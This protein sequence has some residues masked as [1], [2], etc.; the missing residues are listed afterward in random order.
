M[1]TPIFHGFTTASRSVWKR[2][3]STASPPLN[4]CLPP[5][6]ARCI[7]TVHPPRNSHF[8]SAY[9]L[10]R[11]LFRRFTAAWRFW[12]F[13]SNNFLS[14]WRRIDRPQNWT[15]LPK[16]GKVCFSDSP[17]WDRPFR[18]TKLCCQLTAENSAFLYLKRFFSKIGKTA[19]AIKTEFSALTKDVRSFAHICPHS[20]LHNFV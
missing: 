1:K 3:V 19:G 13:L 9:H 18:G 20:L 11:A 16:I 4:V 10:H 12:T 6:Q 15:H 5:V 8:S 17:I 14:S 7:S 2:C